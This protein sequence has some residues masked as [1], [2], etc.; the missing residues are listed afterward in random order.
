MKDHTRLH[1]C[2]FILYVLLTSN[3]PLTRY[4]YVYIDSS[5]SDILQTTGPI[6]FNQV[7]TQSLIAEGNRKQGM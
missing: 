2:R 3:Y 1:R 7:K 6:C 5:F 4:I